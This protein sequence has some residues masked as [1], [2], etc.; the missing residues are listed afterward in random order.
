MNNKV[1]QLV[2][3]C[4]GKSFRKYNLENCLS[5]KAYTMWL[6]FPQQETTGDPPLLPT[7]KNQWHSYLPPWRELH[8]TA[9]LKMDQSP[10]LILD[11][12]GKQ[13]AMGQG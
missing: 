3:C 13:T 9:G 10:A 7:G 6:P 4:I 8:Q 12:Y 2:M 5:N 1:S 11:C